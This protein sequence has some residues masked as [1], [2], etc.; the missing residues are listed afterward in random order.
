MKSFRDGKL[1]PYEVLQYV[2]DIALTK[3]ILVIESNHKCIKAALP[4]R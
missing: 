4:H 3:Q 1:H 2:F